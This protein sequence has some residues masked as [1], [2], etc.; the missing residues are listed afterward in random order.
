[1]WMIKNI[2]N[3]GTKVVQFAKVFNLFIF[4]I[5]RS[6]MWKFWCWSGGNKYNPSFIRMQERA[7]YDC[8]CFLTLVGSKA[9][10]S[11][12]N[13]WDWW[14]VLATANWI[15]NWILVIIWNW[16]SLIFIF[17]NWLNWCPIWLNIVCIKVGRLISS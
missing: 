3:W 14:M 4:S 15:R 6:S 9:N 16:F 10:L 7:I 2:Y 17:D 12:N 11:N 1:M 13:P 5:T 8:P